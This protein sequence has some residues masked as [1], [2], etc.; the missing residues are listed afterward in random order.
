MRRRPAD[1][2]E[3]YSSPN[4][5]GIELFFGLWIFLVEQTISAERFIHILMEW[6]KGRAKSL[7]YDAKPPLHDRA[8][9]VRKKLPDPCL[10]PIHYE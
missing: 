3:I 5:V 10:V 1:I 7:A 9:S 4:D 6:T 2:V 8:C